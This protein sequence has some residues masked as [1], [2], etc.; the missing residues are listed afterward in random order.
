MDIIKLRKALLAILTILV[1]T[2]S[3]YI[4]ITK[5]KNY[6]T[7][8]S[9]YQVSNAIN[10]NSNLNKTVSAKGNLVFKVKY[11]KSGDIQTENE[12]SASKLAGKTKSEIE[13]IYEKSGYNVDS[14]N[15]LQ[16]VLIRNVDK[17]APN[18]YVV[19]IKDGFIAIYKT[20][21]NGNMFIE[22]STRDVTDIK[23]SRLKQKDIELL[24]NGDKYFECDTLEDAKARLED[25]E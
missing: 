17:Y 5:L 10:T 6:N 19:G 16:V 22:D 18:K 25:Y 24:T 20:D 7:K 23:T 13:S 9:T 8:K 14:F 4:C 1:F 12:E 3:C 11:S 2:V 21:K 15:S